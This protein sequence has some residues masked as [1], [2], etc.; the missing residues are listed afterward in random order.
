MSDPAPSWIPAEAFFPT[1]MRAA[2]AEIADLRARLATSEAARAT[3]SEAARRAA[4][5]L[6]ALRERYEARCFPIMDGTDIPWAAIA[7]FE[8]QAKKNHGGQSLEGLANRGGLSTLEAIHV[9]ECVEW[10][11][12]RS[13]G[14]RRM[15]KRDAALHLDSLARA[16]LSSGDSATP[17]AD[18]AGIDAS[19]GRILVADYDEWR[20]FQ[21]WK[22]GGKDRR[23]R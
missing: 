2:E 10:G 12:D 13:A 3:A 4:A 22:A 21:A 18:P 11:G 1:G 6:D 17:L 19:P 7:L 15:G 20:A 23:R 9:F 14:I 16:A 8:E 5:E